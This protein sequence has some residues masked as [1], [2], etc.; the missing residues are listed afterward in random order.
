MYIFLFISSFFLW[1]DL[2]WG[3]SQYADETYKVK[4]LSSRSVRHVQMFV[5]FFGH[6]NSIHN[7]IP[8][9]KKEMIWT[10]FWEKKNIILNFFRR[11][12]AIFSTL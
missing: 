7:I 5:R 9:L 4:Q 10:S 6:G 8:L 12:K 11:K 1:L 3:R 2:Q